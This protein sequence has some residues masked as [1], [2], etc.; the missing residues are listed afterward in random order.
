MNFHKRHLKWNGWSIFFYW[1]IFWTL[2]YTSLWAS[3]MFEPALIKTISFCVYTM[4]FENFSMSGK[5][6]WVLVCNSSVFEN[7]NEIFLNNLIS[8]KMIYALII[9]Q[10]EFSS[11]SLKISI[12]NNK[13]KVLQKM[14]KL[15]I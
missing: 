6:G 3:R 9:Y 15:G 5:R 10:T 11:E 12:T 1:K 14:R 8:L 2:H 7:F 13:I 4:N